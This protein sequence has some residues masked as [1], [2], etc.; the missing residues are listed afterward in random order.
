MEENRR[1]I[2]HFLMK[3]LNHPS[4]KLDG[5]QKNVLEKV[6]PGSK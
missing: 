6:E 3:I 5:Q 1:F 4:L 2:Y